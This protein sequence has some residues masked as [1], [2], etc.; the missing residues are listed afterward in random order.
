MKAVRFS[1]Y[2][3]VDVLRVADV[4]PPSCPDDGVVVRVRAAGINPGEANIRTGALHDRFPATFPSGQGS[5]FAGVVSEIGAAVTGWAVEDEVLGW[6]WD[7]ASHAEQVAAP[8]SQIVRKPRSLAWDVAGSLY[9]AGSTAY[10]AVR[11][12]EPRPGDMIAVSG[13]AGGVGCIAIQLLRRAGARVIAIASSRHAEWLR[14]HGAVVVDY[15]GG[16][17]ERLRDAA[18]PRGLDAFIDLHGDGYV[19]TALELGVSP[20]R[21][22]T[23][24][25]FAAAQKYGVHTAGS[26]EGTSTAILAELAQLASHGD[27]DVPIAA[28]YPLTDVREAFFDLERRHTLGKIV[29]KP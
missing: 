22:N 11:A 8:A 26:A 13:A 20:D 1:H 5:D 23:V 4:A 28:T 10:A 16:L 29:L 2:G 21:V 17:V 15:G 14:D 7:R 3:P 12:I 24:I 25:D 19:S 27:I 6:S 9:I 18:Q